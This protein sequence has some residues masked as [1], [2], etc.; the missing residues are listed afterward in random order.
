MQ[1]IFPRSIRT[2]L[3]VVFTLLAAGSAAPVQTAVTLWQFETGRLL[4]GQ[5]TLPLEPLTT[6]ADGSATAYL[7]Q[8][9]N[10]AKLTTQNAA[11]VT[12]VTFPSTSART[13][14]ASASGWIEPF[15]TDV[16]IECSFVRSDF[17]QCVLINGTAVVPSNSGAP[18]TQVLQIASSTSLPPPISS[19]SSK[20][21]TPVGAIVGAVITILVVG[22]GGLFAFVILRRRRQRQ[23]WEDE[24]NAARAF[25]AAVVESTNSNTPEQPIVSDPHDQAELGNARA[26]QKYQEV[27]GFRV[28]ASDGGGVSSVGTSDVGGNRVSSQ[29]ASELHTS[30]LVQLLAQRVQLEERAA[31]PYALVER[32]DV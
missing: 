27:Q 12:T 24:K 3:F 2:V 9:V 7:Y 26:P 17:G 6:A 23:M 10:N 1:V 20:H 8:V 4:P 29:I 18:I 19:S 28:G 32:G 22:V 30:D 16:A 25:D 11:G 14:I 21:S 15:S 13:I 31:P 5:L